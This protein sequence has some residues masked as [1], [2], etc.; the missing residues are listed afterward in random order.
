MSKIEED[1]LACS[2]QRQRNF[3]T[4]ILDAIER[5]DIS[6]D[7]VKDS[8]RKLEDQLRGLRKNAL[9]ARP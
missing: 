7:Q 2:L 5:R 6:T 3:L 4:E 9:F 1:V 8:L